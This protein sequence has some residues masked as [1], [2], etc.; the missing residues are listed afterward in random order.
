MRFEFDIMG[1]NK[2]KL[3]DSLHTGEFSEKSNSRFIVYSINIRFVKSSY[4][5]RNC[6]LATGF[7]L[8]YVYYS[9]CLQSHTTDC[10]V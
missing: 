3:M 2:I 4:I 7:G 5:R 10:R 9:V 1:C 6:G 8:E